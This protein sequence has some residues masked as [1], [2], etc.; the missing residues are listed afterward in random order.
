MNTAIISNVLIKSSNC[1]CFVKLLTIEMA[2]DT[3]SHTYSGDAY[4]ALARLN[5][6]AM[7]FLESYVYT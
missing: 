7:Y 3:D 2:K 4:S 6:H 5:I 1:D